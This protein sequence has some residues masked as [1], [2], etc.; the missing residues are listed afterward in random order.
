MN[1]QSERSDRM[2]FLKSMQG[3]IA[4]LDDDNVGVYAAQVAY[5]ILL[6]F[7]P[8]LMLLLPMV[9][10]TPITEELVTD[11]ILNI[12][13]DAG[14]LRSVLLSIIQ[15]VYNKSE[16]IMPISALLALWSAG[17]GIMALT[18]GVNTI[19]HVKE[20][21]GYLR[22]RIRSTLYTLLM[23][24]AV[25]MC[26]LILVFGNEIQKLIAKY[27]PFI[28]TITAYIIGMRTMISLVVLVLIFLLIYT[29]L[30]NRR[31]SIKSQ[32]PGAVISAIVWSLFSLAFSFYLSTFDGFSYM[33][34]SLTTLIFIM[35]WLY[36][37]IYILLIGAELNAY[38]EEKWRMV[39]KM[40]SDKIREE[41]LEFI[42]GLKEDLF[43]D[44]DD[45]LGSGEARQA[46]R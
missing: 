11:I 43:D 39:H 7:I 20:T 24:V 42:D 41:Y 33:Y 36:F 35:L 46:G 38:F 27:I 17:K 23:T 19:Y 1:K 5:F 26:L 14:E 25:I 22:T 40:A 18:N 6:S 45:E 10:F 21:R 12:M 13:P 15:E 44:Y 28:E 32:V 34:G 37:C 4:R 29:F 16:A 30:P 9:R 2:K 3:F 31:A 8:F